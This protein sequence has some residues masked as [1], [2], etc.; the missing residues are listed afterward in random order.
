VERSNLL[1]VEMDGWIKLKETDEWFDWIQPI[2]SS[3]HLGLLT[4]Q[5]YIIGKFLYQQNTACTV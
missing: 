3:F 1:E 2:Q 5:F 4:S